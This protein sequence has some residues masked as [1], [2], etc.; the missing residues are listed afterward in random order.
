MLGQK[1]KIGLVTATAF[2]VGAMIGGGVF[3][4]T[5]V[6]MQQTGPSAI[7]S[8]L[9][10]GIIVLLSALSFAVIAARTSSKESGYA[11]IGDIMGSPIWGF[12]TSWCFYLNGIICAA[13]VLNAFGDYMHQFV[14]P[15][16]PT[17]SWALIGA[18][19]L[20]LVNLGP[21]SAIGKIETFLVTGKLLVL[22]LLV[23][24]GVAHFQTSDFNNFASHGVMQIFATSSFLFIAFLGFNVITSIAG[25][26]DEPQKT[27]PRAILLSMLIV[28]IVYMGVVIALVAGHI[29]D[30]SE[31]SVGVAAQHLIGPVGGGLIVAGA[32]VSTLSAA[33]A[34]I[35]GSS[36]IMVRLAHRKQVPT[37]LGHLWHGHPYMSVI[38]GAGLY[39]LLIITRQ[40]NMVI[41]LAN[42]TA[43]VALLI[44]NA[45]AVRVLMKHHRS[46][47]RLPGKGLLPVLGGLGAAVQFVFIPLPTLIV[48]IGLI[49]IGSLVYTVRERYFLPKHHR[50]ITQVV[51]DVDGPL[52]RTLKT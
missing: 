42:T 51:Q 19:V 44:V 48:G 27:V 22:V 39:C 40:T 17:I 29:S 32:L 47:L 31:A 38:A 35:L 33:N 9:F 16:V 34:N 12:L 36:E 3:V 13:F 7:L 1:K 20:T 2:A 30:Y 23:I 49:G 50:Q 52:A 8:F 25:D 21:A 4:L 18:A 26:V 46:G 5:G 41:G 10:A 43:I 37:R 14:T 45:A 6:A 24:F 15:S 28:T 11:G